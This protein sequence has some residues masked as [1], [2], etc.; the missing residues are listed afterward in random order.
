MADPKEY[1]FILMPKSKKRATIRSWKYHLLALNEAYDKKSINYLL[2][3]N[4][5]ESLF[6]KSEGLLEFAGLIASGNALFEEERRQTSMEIDHF[7]N[8]ATPIL[9]TG[10]K[11]YLSSKGKTMI[12][13]WINGNQLPEGT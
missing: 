10:Y 3:L 12:E 4:K 2:L 13:S 11:I 1:T 7:A 9:E 8:I 6:L 5:V